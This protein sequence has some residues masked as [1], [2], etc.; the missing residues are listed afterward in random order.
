MKNSLSTSVNK[1][2]Q[3]LLLSQSKLNALMRNLFVFQ[4]SVGETKT[5]FSFDSLRPQ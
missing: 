4:N 2:A 3:C 1:F 5:S